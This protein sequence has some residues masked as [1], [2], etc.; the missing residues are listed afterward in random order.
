MNNEDAPHPPPLLHWAALSAFKP[1]G[2][3][4][5]AGRASGVTQRKGGGWDATQIQHCCAFLMEK[6]RVKQVRTPHHC[7][8]LLTVRGNERNSFFHVTQPDSQRRLFSRESGGGVR[9]GG[10][11]LSRGNPPPPR[12]VPNNLLSKKQQRLIPHI[13]A[14]QLETQAADFPLTLTAS[15]EA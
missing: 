12:K 7:K 1:A 4:A 11:G 15:T 9:E 2:R 13:S 3:E 8:P 5:A 6:C 10:G 14:V